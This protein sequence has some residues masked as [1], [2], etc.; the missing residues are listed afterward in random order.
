ARIAVIES[1]LALFGGVEAVA[2]Y[3]VA[4][5]QIEVALGEEGIE[6]FE[7]R[8]D[9]LTCAVLAGALIGIECPEVVLGEERALVVARIPLAADEQGGAHLRPFSV[10]AEDDTLENPAIL[11]VHRRRKAQNVA[12]RAAQKSPVG[13]QPYCGV[14]SRPV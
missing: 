8:D 2:E 9:V 11:G 4:D 13:E 6:P 7:G 12:H 5:D 14:P 1:R 10:M 3:A